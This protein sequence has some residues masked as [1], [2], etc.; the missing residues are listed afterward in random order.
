MLGELTG[1]IL[2]EEHTVLPMAMIYYNERIQRKFSKEK[3][4]IRSSPEEIRY[5]IK[6]SIPSSHTKCA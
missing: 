4:N 2:T 5:K 6:Q 3:K 1:L